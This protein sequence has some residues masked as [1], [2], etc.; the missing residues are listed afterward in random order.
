MYQ[1]RVFISHNIPVSPKNPSNNQTEKRK[2]QENIVEKH[3]KNKIK[4]NKQV[5]KY[6]YVVWKR[7]CKTKKTKKKKKRNRG[8]KKKRNKTVT[9]TR[10]RFVYDINFNMSQN[11]HDDK[12]RNKFQ[13]QLTIC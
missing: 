12:L 6:K 2:A 13:F 7:K 9:E 3:I 11:C 10:Y 4:L 5:T 8:G 1:S